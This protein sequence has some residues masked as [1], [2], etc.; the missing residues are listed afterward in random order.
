MKLAL[1]ILVLV[2]AGCG[3]GDYGPDD[4]DDTPAPSVCAGNPKACI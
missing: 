1:A 2:L 4:A 3:G